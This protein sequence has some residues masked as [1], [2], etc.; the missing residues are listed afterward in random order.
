MQVM[1][2]QTP[3]FIFYKLIYEA[4][5]CKCYLMVAQTPIFNFYKLIYE[6]IECK[7]YLMVAQTPIF[8]FYKLIYSSPRSSYGPTANTRDMHHAFC[9]NGIPT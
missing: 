7:C 2:A 4:I 5:E 9:A 1:V 3:I 8:N 6:A